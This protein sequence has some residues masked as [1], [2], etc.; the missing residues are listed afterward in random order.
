MYACVSVCMC[1][2]LCVYTLQNASPL[3]LPVI[4]YLVFQYLDKIGQLFFGLPPPAP[5]SQGLFG[6]LKT[7]LCIILISWCAGFLFC[8]SLWLC[9]FL[10]SG[11]FQQFDDS[12]NRA[13]LNWL[14]SCTFVHFLCPVPR[15][16]SIKK[17]FFFKWA[18]QHSVLSLICNFKIWIST[19]ILLMF[20][21]DC[22]VSRTVN[23]TFYLWFGDLINN[24][25]IYSTISHWQGWACWALQH[26]K[27][28]T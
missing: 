17:N 7:Y 3:Y 22:V 2:R 18:C 28:Y 10:S 19:L 11:I 1:V 15:G 13:Q 16:T 9:D 14:W 5:A 4:V 24:S 26:N 20:A 21:V 25:D 12:E 27:M 8:S 23:Q 6:E